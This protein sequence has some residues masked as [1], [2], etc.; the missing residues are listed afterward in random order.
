MAYNY[1]KELTYLA[2]VTA[3]SSATATFTSGI[4]SNFSSYLIKLRNVV[5]ATNAT[6]LIFRYTTNGGGSWTATNSEYAIVEANT[7]T[8]TRTGVDGTTSPVIV[9]VNSSTAANCLNGE[10]FINGSQ[11]AKS[12]LSYFSGIHV[13]SNAAI[14][15]MASAVTSRDNVT[16]INGFRLLFSAGNIASGSFYLYGVTEP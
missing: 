14:S 2:T 3:S 4:S 9:R 10:L 15:R 11:T 5:P 7:S 16:A 13:D 1:P 6:T 8:L 12:P